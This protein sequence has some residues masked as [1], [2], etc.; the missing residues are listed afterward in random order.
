MKLITNLNLRQN[1]RIML[2]IFT[3]FVTIHKVNGQSKPKGN[4]EYFIKQGLKSSTATEG[5]K[6]VKCIFKI[7]EGLLMYN[8]DGNMVWRSPTPKITALGQFYQLLNG[9]GYFNIDLV[10]TTI[11]PVSA[12]VKVKFDLS[13]TIT[14]E[15]NTNEKCGC[16]SKGNTIYLINNTL[17]SAKVDINHF[18]LYQ[19]RI[20]QVDRYSLI[21]KQ[22]LKIG[23]DWHYCTKLAPR[24]YGEEFNLRYFTLGK[25]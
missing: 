12:Q 6:P 5:L 17:L 1:A 10:D 23:C 8:A 22:R 19:G 21:G 20:L 2:I 25:P 4:L 14:L 3:A 13:P 11:T 9:A 16:T 7:K 15:V 24:G 18:L